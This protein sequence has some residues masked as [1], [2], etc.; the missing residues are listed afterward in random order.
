MNLG[1]QY[2]CD[3]SL[4]EFDHYIAEAERVRIQKSMSDVK[5]VYATR[6]GTTGGSFQEAEIVYVLT[7]HC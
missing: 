1:S 4:A 6:D 7:C 5:F 3:K 2:R